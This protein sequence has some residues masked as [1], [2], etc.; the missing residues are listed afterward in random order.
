ME[1]IFYPFIGAT[2]S[3]NSFSKQEEGTQITP[4]LIGQ[5]TPN[6]ET[7]INSRIVQVGGVDVATFAS[8]SVNQPA[9]AAITAD[10][11]YRLKSNVDNN[12]SPVDIFSPSRTVDFIFPFFY[13]TSNEAVRADVFLNTNFYSGGTKVINNGS[14]QIN[15]P[16]SGTGFLWFAV[17]SSI[18]V[19][20]TWFESILNNGSI[21][22]PLD[23]FD[24]PTV[25]VINSSGLFNDYSQNYNIYVTNF[26]TTGATL[27]IS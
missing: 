4:Q 3:L 24:A 7:T 25:Q 13:G 18:P 17:E 15:I 16:F 21:G 10:T 20:T 2:L 26:Q 22:T 19:K 14:G 27:Q 9:P 6:Q 12:G 23:L 8:N 5:L 1:S 11:T